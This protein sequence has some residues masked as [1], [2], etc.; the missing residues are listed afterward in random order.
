MSNCWSPGQTDTD[1]PNYGLCCFDGCANTC[2][3]GPQGTKKHAFMKMIFFTILPFSAASDS[4]PVAQSTPGPIPQT[5]PAPE[6]TTGY[7]YPVPDVTLPIR[8]IVTT[9]VPIT[10][11]AT[12]YGAPPPSRQGRQGRQ[13]RR[14]R[15][16]RRNGR[17]R[18]VLRR[19]L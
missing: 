9:P 12:L 2:V 17:R 18:K 3:D 10:T 16:G 7:N 15:K 8:P 14:G 5:T 13:G 1:C 4:R 19:R 6:V 11:P